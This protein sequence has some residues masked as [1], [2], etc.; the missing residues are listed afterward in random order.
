MYLITSLLWVWISLMAKCT[1]CD[2]A[3]QWLAAGLWFSLG[4]LFSTLINLELPP[5]FVLHDCIAIYTFGVTSHFYF[6]QLHCNL[7]IWSYL[8]FLSFAWLHC[9][10][11]NWSYLP[12]IN[13]ARL[14]CNLLNWSYLPF[15][16]RLHCNLLNWSYLPFLFNAI[17][18]QSINLELPPFFALHDCIAI[19]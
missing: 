19:Y 16:A 7:L 13:V 6:L 1:L 18:L 10:L 2:K 9:N 8:P 14:H 5:F 3:C 12:F 15:F 4:T 17:A 11:L